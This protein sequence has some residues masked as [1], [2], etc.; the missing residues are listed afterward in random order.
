MVITKSAVRICAGRSF[1]PHA[2]GPRSGHPLA[3][4]R[5][6]Q[7]NA[8]RA[9]LGQT[10]ELLAQEHEHIGGGRRQ[11]GI[12]TRWSLNDVHTHS[13][14]RIFYAERL[15]GLSVEDWPVRPTPNAH[16]FYFALRLQTGPVP[17]RHPTVDGP[18]S[19]YRNV[20]SSNLG[21]EIIFYLEPTG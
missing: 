7:Q 8:A 11:A 15:Q 5:L 1:W 10:R 3:G 17:L 20:P 16:Y 13:P 12:L 19:G 9:S 2:Q 4:G 14:S 18:A 6:G 21:D